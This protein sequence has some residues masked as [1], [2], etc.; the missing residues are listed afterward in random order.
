MSA[1]YK[2]GNYLI[3]R[4]LFYL[5]WKEIIKKAEILNTDFRNNFKYKCDPNDL[6]INIINDK[7]TFFGNNNDR[8]DDG[9][10]FLYV[11]EYSLPNIIA[12]YIINLNKSNSLINRGLEKTDKTDPNKKSRLS[13]DKLFKIFKVLENGVPE[14]TKEVVCVINKKYFEILLIFCLD[15]EDSREKKHYHFSNAF[16]GHFCKSDSKIEKINYK[17]QHLFV[18]SYLSKEK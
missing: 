14:D 5:F 4:K 7:T 16:N 13:G 17:K 10:D 3:D 6:S 11:K 9:Q 2:D 8:V 15:I 12:S 18:G 1:N